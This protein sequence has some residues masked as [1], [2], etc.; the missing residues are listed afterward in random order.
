M[1]QA[2]STIESRYA[3]S[4]AISQTLR[5]VMLPTHTLM[6]HVLYSEGSM[7]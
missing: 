3:R 4:H 2:P 5:L 6:L 7:R 1:I